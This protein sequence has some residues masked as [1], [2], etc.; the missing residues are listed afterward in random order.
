MTIFNLLSDLNSK[1]IPD[2]VLIMDSL[3]DNYDISV[4]QEEWDIY[5]TLNR[6]DNNIEVATVR[7]SETGTFIVE[8]F[9]HENMEV[10]SFHIPPFR[11]WADDLLAIILIEARIAYKFRCN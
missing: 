1:P 11:K 9:I 10:N 4:N 8:N 3:I 6:S 5:V 7:L 2:A